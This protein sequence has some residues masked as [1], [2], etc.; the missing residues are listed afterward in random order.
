MAEE[1]NT[2]TAEPCEETAATESTSA[3]EKAPKKAKSK[4]QSELDALKAELQAQKDLLLRTAAEFDN[5]KKRT[6]RETERIGV[7]TRANVIKQLLPALDNFLRASENGVDEENAQLVEYKKGVDMSIKQFTDILK[8]MGVEEIDCLGK[9]FDPNFHFAVQKVEDE[10]F[11]ENCV[12]Q[13]F[14]KGY[15]LG[16]IVIRTAMVAVA[17]CDQ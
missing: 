17:N 9:E 3:T 6:A 16:D 1:K 15:V 14:Q 8:K 11:G 2:N 13:V 10:N 12:S 7:E 5:Y 4:K